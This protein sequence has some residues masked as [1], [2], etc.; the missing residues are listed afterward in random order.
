MQ[1][2]LSLVVKQLEIWFLY[3][4]LLMNSSKTV[5]MSFQLCHSIPTY[6]PHILLQNN[7]IEYK[8]VVK[9]LVLTFSRR[10]HLILLNRYLTYAPNGC[11]AAI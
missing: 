4:D 11:A 7:G 3:N 10:M 6:K 9:F 2:K 1:T 5:D 8:S